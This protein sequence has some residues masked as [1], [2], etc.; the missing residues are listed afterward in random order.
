MPLGGIGELTVNIAET[1][2]ATEDLVDV[3]HLEN[4]SALILYSVISDSGWS[5][6]M[7]T[8]PQT[9]Y[10]GGTWSSWTSMNT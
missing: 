9:T 4:A 1:L 7:R 2:G 10:G 3:V 5:T 8:K 6:A